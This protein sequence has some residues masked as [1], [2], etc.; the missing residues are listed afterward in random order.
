MCSRW[1]VA[2]RRRSDGSTWLAYG[3]AAFEK[4]KAEAEAKAI[5]K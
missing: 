4:E 3:G 1:A 2:C 5:E